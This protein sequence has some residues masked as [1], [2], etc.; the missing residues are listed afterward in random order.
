MHPITLEKLLLTEANDLSRLECKYVCHFLVLYCILYSVA[1]SLS[2]LE[3]ALLYDVSL[4]PDS[5]S[6]LSVTTICALVGNAPN[7]AFVRT[8]FISYIVQYLLKEIIRLQVFTQPLRFGCRSR[9][10]ALSASRWRQQ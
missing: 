7:H 3:S 10:R 9:R 1:V 8:V 6:V 2:L 5:I 4:H